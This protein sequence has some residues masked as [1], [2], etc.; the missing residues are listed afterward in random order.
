ML[1]HPWV[2]VGP[3][4]DRKPDIELK[5]LGVL[6]EDR[7]VVD[8]AIRCHSLTR[9]ANACDCFDPRRF[10]EA[11]ELHDLEIRQMEE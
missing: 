5:R 7:Y 4:V 10:D 8:I 3:L 6:I 1:C 11:L 2:R 9:S